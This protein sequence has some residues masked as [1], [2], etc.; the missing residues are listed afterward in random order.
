MEG[1]DKQPAE[2]GA[3]DKPMQDKVKSALT[4]LQGEMESLKS[5]LLQKKLTTRGPSGASS[6]NK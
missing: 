2:H 4:D 6:K 1:D 3:M 5:Q